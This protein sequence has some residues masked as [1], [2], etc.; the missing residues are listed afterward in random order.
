MT[1]TRSAGSPAVALSELSPELRKATS[2]AA[3]FAWVGR[4][5]TDCN[6][7]AFALD[8]AAHHEHSE[9]VRDASVQLGV[10]EPPSLALAWRF[11]QAARFLE[12]HDFDTIVL[13][14]ART[15]GA[16]IALAAVPEAVLVLD[17]K[18]LEAGASL[19]YVAK[20]RGGAV[21][22]K[23]GA[24]LAVLTLKDAGRDE[25]ASREVPA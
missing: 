2:T 11:F 24:L 4:D 22:E 21:M 18:Q 6:S 5:R 7:L 25:L 20:T 3:A 12:A 23:D 13:T 17:V 10:G 16:R 19:S 9:L 8:M 15:L 14:R 1:R